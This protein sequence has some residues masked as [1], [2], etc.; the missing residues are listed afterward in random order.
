MD[1][2]VVPLEFRALLDRVF[3]T[4]DYDA[5]M[6]GLGGGDADPNGE[7]NVWLSRGSNHLWRLGQTTPATPVGSGDRSPHAAAARHARRI[8]SASAST[9]ACRRSSPNS[10]RS[11]SWPR[12]TSSS[13]RAATS[14]ISSRRCS[15][16]TRCGMS[17]RMFFTPRASRSAAADEHTG[18]HAARASIR[19]SHGHRA[20]VGVPV[21][22]DEHA[23]SE[24]IDRYSRL[25]FS[26]PLRQGLT[27]EEA[28]DMFQAVCLDLVAELP[29]LRD[30]Q[31]LPAWL[32]RTTRAQGRPS[33]GGAT[34]ASS[35]TRAHIAEHAPEPRTTAGLAD[36]AAASRHRR[37]ATASR[38]LPD[39]CQRDGPHAVLRD[40]GAS[41]SRTSRRRSASPPARSDS[42]ACSA[43]TGFGRSLER[44]GLCR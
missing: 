18:A 16:T 26:I 39:R 9:T 38:R 15:I 23:W 37:C 1:V 13:A 11:S 10:C 27:R 34:N 42:C 3:Q 6:L 36:R 24:L 40:A 31:A 41:L 30:P 22:G 33:G 8:A 17:E 14:A 29:R 44:I 28:A 4:F 25:I 35:P 19:S 43:S 32:I 21:S 20:G 2:Q 12:P 5:S 7:M